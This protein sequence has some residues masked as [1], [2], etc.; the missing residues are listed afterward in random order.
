MHSDTHSSRQSIGRTR[1]R[2]GSCPPSCPAWLV[3]S[4]GLPS[5]LD[6]SY[7]LFLCPRTHWLP[8]TI[9]HNISIPKLM[10]EILMP[11]SP[12]WFVALIRFSDVQAVLDS[13]VETGISPTVNDLFKGFTYGLLDAI[14]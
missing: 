11:D 10:L 1:L 5:S 9:S 7:A 8:G 14:A 3:C 2:S 4:P 12:S 6:C 13:P